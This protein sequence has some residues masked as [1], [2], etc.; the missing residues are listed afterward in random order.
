M[1]RFLN[2]LHA[3]LK[4]DKIWIL[5]YPLFYYSDILQEIV[6]IPKGFETD[7]ASVP[8]VPFVY[9]FWGG[10]AHREAILHDYLYRLDSDPV[11]SFKDANKIFLEAMKARQKSR[12]VRWPMYLGVC[13]G[14]IGSYHKKYVFDKL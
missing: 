14:G 3:S 8:R 2:Q 9:W 1:S 12:C 4:D 13:F 10:K 11:V 7:L 6:K 5:D